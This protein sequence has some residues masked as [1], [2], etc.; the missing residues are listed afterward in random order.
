M[1]AHLI[2]VMARHPTEKNSVVFYGPRV[3]HRALDVAFRQWLPFHS[4]PMI[5]NV[6]ASGHLI[7]RPSSMRTRIEM[8][9]TKSQRCKRIAALLWVL[10]VSIVGISTY[11]KWG[12]TRHL[13]VAAYPIADAQIYPEF[14]FAVKYQKRYAWLSGTE[15][16]LVATDPNEIAALRADA[17]AAFDWTFDDVYGSTYCFTND[18][19]R[20]PGWTKRD[21]MQAPVE[22]GLQ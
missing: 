7:G 8:R 19:E 6:V 12:Y 5:R 1:A 18:F 13:A 4:F 3:V 21:P 10:A 9:N 2:S 20:L 14:Q 11:G 22:P 16:W 15:K 17:V